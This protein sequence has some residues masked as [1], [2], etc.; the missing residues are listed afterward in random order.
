MCAHTHTDATDDE[1]KDRWYDDLQGVLDAIRR[2]DAVIVIGDFNA[3]VG[4]EVDAFCGA[5]GGVSLHLQ[6]NDNGIRLATMA[7]QKTSPTVG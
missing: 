4:R 5:I 1:E 7:I 2:H 6:L 3:K